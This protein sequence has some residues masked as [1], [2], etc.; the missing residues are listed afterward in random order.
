MISEPT[1]NV[2]QRIAKFIEIRL[3]K[4]KYQWKDRKR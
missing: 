3:V 2:P 4:Q 1:L